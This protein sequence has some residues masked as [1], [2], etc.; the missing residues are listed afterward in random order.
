MN[1][2]ARARLSARLAT[3]GLTSMRLCTGS[4][5]R[6]T[7]HQNSYYVAADGMAG[8]EP[9]PLLLHIT[10]ASA[11]SSALFPKALLL[12][13]MRPAGGREVVV[14]AVPFGFRDAENIRAF[15]EKLD[16]AF[17]PRP[18]GALPAIT[19]GGPQPELNLPAAIEAFRQVLKNTGVNWT[20]I[21]APY[22]VGLW[23]T[24]RA[25]WREGYAAE[26]ESI[27]IAGD[28][29]LNHAKELIRRSAG[30]TRFSV[31]SSVAF[32]LPA[33]AGENSWLLGQFANPVEI[34]GVEYSFDADELARLA[35]RF[36]RPLK[37]AEELHDFI[38]Q[39]KA[40]SGLGRGFDF[41]LSLGG[42][43]GLTTARDLIFCLQWLR[44]RGRAAQAVSPNL[45]PGTVA[46]LAA[47]ARHFNATLSVRSDGAVWEELEAIGQATAGRV[48][49]RI[50]GEFDP[51]SLAGLAARLRG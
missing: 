23:A 30:Y 22:E 45:G 6:D 43:G 42:S 47:V 2:D 25:G 28:S 32:G 39:T 46:E 3:L 36:S 33:G 9:A 38:R 44:T 14:N 31:D 11:P 7:V 4:L 20:S 1:D 16:R 12:G 27:V 19:V 24:I 29:D 41:E 37:L 15:A 48:Y 49:Y 5:V 8:P 34:G 17:L 26:A 40:R 51:S 10:L 13:R 35:A 18:Q 50:S 21:A